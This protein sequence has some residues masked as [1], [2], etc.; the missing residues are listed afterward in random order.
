MQLQLRYTNYTPPHLQLH[1]AT[2]TTTAAL[3]HTAS[4]SCGW[5]DRPGDRCNHCIHSKKH[6]SNHLWVHQ[7]I[8]FAIR[9]SQQ[10]SSPIG[11]LLLKLPPPPCAVLLVFIK[12]TRTIPILIIF[13]YAL[14]SSMPRLLNL[15]FLLTKPPPNSHEKQLSPQ[16][17]LLI[18]LK[19]CNFVAITIRW[20]RWESERLES[21]DLVQTATAV[22]ARHMGL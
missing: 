12:F 13:P 22:K 10:P 14:H 3:H 9:D 18:S 15:P 11:F 16:F 17:L 20:P 6:N 5:G 21:V 1:Y 7:W 2:T 8:R 4:S 19:D